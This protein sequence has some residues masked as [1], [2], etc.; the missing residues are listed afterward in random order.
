MISRSLSRAAS[1][2]SLWRS[3]TSN[4][5]ADYDH[6]LHKYPWL[7]RDDEDNKDDDDQRFSYPSNDNRSTLRCSTP[8]PSLPEVGQH[9]TEW[10][11]GVGQQPYGRLNGTDMERESLDA[12]SSEG[13]VTGAGPRLLPTTLVAE[14]DPA[15]IEDPHLVGQNMLAR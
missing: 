7:S 4:P 11:F 2:S 10:P 13:S 12:S 5:T 15:A 14:Q 8:L 1:K 9:H 6:S 3:W